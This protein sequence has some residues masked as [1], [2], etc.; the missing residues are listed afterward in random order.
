M[1]GARLVQDVRFALLRGLRRNPGLTRHDA[2]AGAGHR[3]QHRHLLGG[4]CAGAAAAALPRADELVAMPHGVMYPDFLDVQQ[5]SRSFEAWRPT[6]G[7]RNWW[8]PARGEPEMASRGHHPGRL[9][10]V[11]R[12]RPADGRGSAPGDDRTGRGG[13]RVA[14]AVAT[15][16]G[17]RPGGDGPDLSL[18]G[19]AARD[20]RDATEFRFPI[21]EQRRKCGDGD[22]TRTTPTGSGVA[23]VP[24]G[25]SLGWRPAW[26]SRGRGPRWG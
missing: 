22:A 5:Q 15:P 25:A 2:G 3:R 1:A 4:G 10:R 9:L 26:R 8:W 14:P 24:T 11:L 6:V 18:D 23:T 19:R 13:G 12:R 7:P 21:D 17:R 20:R 16:A